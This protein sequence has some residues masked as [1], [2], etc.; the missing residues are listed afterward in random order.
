[1]LTRVFLQ[2]ESTSTTVDDGIGIEVE[3]PD[4]TTI[5]PLDAD[6]WDPMINK[7]E[8]FRTGA[9][10]FIPRLV[11]GLVAMALAIIA[12]RILARA[13]RHS[14]AASSA[15]PLVV[16]VL[17]NVV[18]Y[19]LIFIAVLFGL[20]AAGIP[21]GTVL[22]GLAVLGL[23]IAFAVQDIGENLISGVLLMF[24]KP[25]KVG[26][27]IITGDYEGTV[28]AIDL[29]ATTLV[30]YDGETILIPNREVYRNPL[31][32][33]TQ[34]GTRRTRVVVGVSYDDD[35][36]EAR[37]VIR[38]ATAAVEGVIDDPEVQVYLLELG[39]SSVNFEI[40]YWTKPDIGSVRSVQDRVISAV[41]R[42]L[43]ENG[44]TIPWPIRTIKFDTPLQ[45]VQ[46][47]QANS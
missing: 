34:R 12:A 46:P 5:N 39:G 32:N 20:A 25:F 40:R 13:I 4:P 22:G 24:R 42:A 41:K 17:S 15:D 21:I 16:S 26:D 14:L 3:G 33:L 2:T 11:V 44:F 47:T 10:A 38:R 29:R 43:D 7:L 18:R 37:D 31:I 28:D 1:M 23:A 8:E 19:S 9:V 30:D 45:M 36:D 6:F 27:Q 35:Q